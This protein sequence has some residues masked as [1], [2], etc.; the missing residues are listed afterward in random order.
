MAICVNNYN[1][2]GKKLLKWYKNFKYILLTR[3][4]LK[5]QQCRKIKSKGLA[6]RRTR[7]MLT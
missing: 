7:P 6:K 5:T 2:L 3:D 4:I 1:F